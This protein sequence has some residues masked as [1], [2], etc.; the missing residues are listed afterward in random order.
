MANT[1]R[2]AISADLAQIVRQNGHA[3]ASKLAPIKPVI[4]FASRTEDDRFA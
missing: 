2:E 4:N 1:N 3:Y